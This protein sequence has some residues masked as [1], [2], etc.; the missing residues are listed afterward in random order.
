MIPVYIS[1]NFLT[2]IRKFDKGNCVQDILSFVD[3][4]NRE[5]FLDTIRALE[6]AKVLI[7]SQEDDER[8]INYCLELLGRP[9]PHL[10][11]FILTEKCNF[12]C[13]YCFIKNQEDSGYNSEDMNLEVALTGLDFFCRLIAEDPNQFKLE[14]KFVFYGGE[15]LLNWN[16]FKFLLIKINEYI[17]NGNLPKETTLNLVTNGSLIT[18]EIA[19]TLNEYGVNISISIDGSAFATNQNRVY[20]DGSPTFQDIKK[21]FLI[22]R[23]IGMAVGASCTLSEASIFNLNTTV[24]ALIDECQV[25][26]LGFNLMLADEGNLDEGY[27]QR[28]SKFIIDAFKIFRKRGV[29]EDRIM[30]KAGSFAKNS[31]WPFDCGAAG[32]NQI[33]IAPNGDIGICHGFLAKRKYFSTT[34]YDAKFS[35]NSD[36]SYAEWSMRSPINMPECQECPALG[37]CGGGCPFQAEVEKGSIWAL[38]ERFCIHAK[39]TLEWLIWDLFNQIKK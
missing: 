15:P 6:S 19:K 9:Y 5:D 35:I 17:K 18:D 4:N 39:M 22:C 24:T 7:T 28:A 37:I 23:S 25:T 29:Y 26:N 30:R 8:A 11:Y 31:I 27:N 38:D 14:K 13:K 36:P 2:L 16:T 32:G 20:S 12:R 21:G 10:V 33:V 34:V 3:P 1:T